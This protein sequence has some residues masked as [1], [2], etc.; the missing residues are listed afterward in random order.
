MVTTL[1][2]T[3]ATVAALYFQFDTSKYG[4]PKLNWMVIPVS[5]SGNLLK[6]QFVINYRGNRGEDAIM[7]N[8]SERIVLQLPDDVTA[9]CV[10]SA[11]KCGDPKAVVSGKDV[12][13]TYRH[14]KPGARMIIEVTFKEEGEAAA[15]K[16]APENR[17]SMDSHIRNVQH[18]R[19]P[20]WIAI[21]AAIVTSIFSVT[22]VYLFLQKGFKFP[23]ELFGYSSADLL[24]FFLALL[25]PIVVTVFCVLRY[26]LIHLCMLF[27][28][29]KRATTSSVT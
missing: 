11:H 20:P 12:R 26:R 22:R 9:A 25:I 2:S 15:A 14:L 13:V 6:W 18:L 17:V 27:F 23:G 8:D 7:R 5:R 3:A 10:L 19:K 28:A 29:R 21:A 1:I 16:T 24:A 4:T